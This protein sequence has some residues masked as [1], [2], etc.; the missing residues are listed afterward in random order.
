MFRTSNVVMIL[1]SHLRKSDTSQGL[2]FFRGYVRLPLST[3]TVRRDVDPRHLCGDTSG[4]EFS[5]SDSE[6]ESTAE[7]I[8]EPSAA[9]VVKEPSP[10][11]ENLEEE[12]P[13]ANDEDLLRTDCAEN[14]R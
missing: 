12:P 11:P 9:S 5:S 14:S 8:M 3:N 1:S 7:K 13:S 10:S 2:R 4:S 6:E